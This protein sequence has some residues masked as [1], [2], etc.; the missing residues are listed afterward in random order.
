MIIGVDAGCLGVS[1]NKLK[2][3]TYY[4][5]FSFLRSLSLLD[6]N[7]N[8]KLYSFLPIEN[9][10]MSKL[11][12][13]MDNVVV[14]PSFGWRHI[15]LPIKLFKDS[16]SVF[17]GISQSL[18]KMLTFPSI[19]FLYDLAFEYF[20]NCYPNPSRLKAITKDAVKR[21]TKI[22]TV[23]FSTRRDLE[24]LYEISGDKVKVIYP[25]VD[26]MFVPQSKKEVQRVLTRYKI[27][28]K[29]YLFV[30]T[31]KPIKNVP[32]VIE[33]FSSFLSKSIE[34]F[35][36][37][38]VG[39]DLWLD[40]GIKET[41]IRDNLERYIKIIGHVPREDLPCFYSGAVAFVSPSLYEGFGMSHAEAMAC[42]APVIAS[43]AGSMPEV[44]GNL[45]ILV[46]PTDAA[47]IAEAMSKIYTDNIYRERLKKLSL[48][49]ARKYSWRKFSA[50]VL[51]TIVEVTKKSGK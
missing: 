11:G 13:N 9:E 43:R 36:L 51:E 29:Y 41:I 6:K 17:L 27:S 5:A 38:L 24:E 23:S 31:L 32:L 4:F 28:E 22:V 7:N 19:I 8:Y 25:G 21:A 26:P 14:Y 44:V 34:K 42:G 10:V 16:P 40:P 48:K 37:V 45:G 1:E 46:N 35:T 18:P 50:E 33:G 20:P 47:E 2:T 3:G 49:Q 30:G 15:C 39:S 12:K